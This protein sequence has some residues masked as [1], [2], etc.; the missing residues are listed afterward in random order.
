MGIGAVKQAMKELGMTTKG[1]KFG[2]KANKVDRALGN[3]KTYLNGELV[4]FDADWPTMIK[5]A[6]KY[7]DEDPEKYGLIKEETLVESDRKK[8]EVVK[9]TASLADLGSKFPFKPGDKV[10]ITKFL[11]YQGNDEEYE[12]E[13]AG[14]KAILTDTMFESEQINEAGVNDLIINE[15]ESEFR[16]IAG[17]VETIGELLGDYPDFTDLA[18]GTKEWQNLLKAMAS[19][20][21]RSLDEVAYDLE[22]RTHQLTKILKK[23]TK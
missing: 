4:V 21:K 5:L 15:L 17:S 9:I 18:I 16:N 23:L 12:V 19:I 20:T 14:K 3:G 13:K 10:K 8:N 22:D 11:G 6:K 2:Y 7:L 1:H